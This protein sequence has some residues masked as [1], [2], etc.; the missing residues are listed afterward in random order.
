MGCFT[1]PNGRRTTQST[2]IP[3]DAPR[4]NERKDNLGVDKETRRVTTGH[5]SSAID[6]YTYLE[7]PKLRGAVGL[8]PDVYAGDNA[9]AGSAQTQTTTNTKP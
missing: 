3:V 2:R 5:C 6:D 1:K 4:A 8:L 7:L 9:E